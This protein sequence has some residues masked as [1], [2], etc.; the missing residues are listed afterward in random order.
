LFVVATTRSRRSRCVSRRRRPPRTWCFPRGAGR[1]GRRTGRG[2]G[3]VRVGRRV[4]SRA[5]VVVAGFSFNQPLEWKTGAVKRMGLM[6]IRCIQFNQ[7]L[8][9]DTS[10][11]EDMSYMFLACEQF[12]RYLGEFAMA[13][14]RLGGDHGAGRRGAP[15]AAARVVD[16][17]TPVMMSCSKVRSSS[18]ERPSLS[19]HLAQSRPIQVL[20][21]AFAH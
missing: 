19:D 15:G 3:R 9:W 10:A 6:F 14:G 7:P 8:E 1:V 5:S 12:N 17:M 21:Q 16:G 13:R 11:V 2:R 20:S 18:A 4:A